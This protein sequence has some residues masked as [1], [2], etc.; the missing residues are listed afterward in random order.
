MDAS[1]GLG[2]VRAGLQLVATVPRTTREASF[3]LLHR[4]VIHPRRSLLRRHLLERRQ[5]IPLG[6]DLVKQP[7]P[8]ASFHSLFESRQHAHGPD[9]R[10]DP[11][12]DG[13]A[14]LFGLLSQ[15]HCRRCVFRR[16]WSFASI[17]LGPFAPPALP[18]FLAT[19][20]PLTPARRLACLG[21]LRQ[22]S[23][24]HVPWPSDHS[25]SNHLVGSVD[26]FDTLPLSVDGFRITP[27]WASPLASRLASTTGRIEF[28][29]VADWSFASRCSPPRLAATQLRS[30]TG[31][32]A[33]A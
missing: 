11:S 6:K 29:C 1:N 26:R 12:P 24:L 8:F 22:V 4:D 17:F 30:V 16:V 3:E 2:L 10:F 15:R 28:T 5:Q 21:W 14:A 32:R 13:D 7:K 20:D 18:G 33:Y 19:M 31:R 9:A 23:L 25:A 27:V